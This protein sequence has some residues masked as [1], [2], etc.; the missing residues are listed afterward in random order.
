MILESKQVGGKIC[1]EKKGLAEFVFKMKWKTKSMLYYGC[2]NGYERE[3]QEMFSQI[4]T[5]TER[6]LDVRIMQND[7]DWMMQVLIGP[8]I[9]D[10]D[11]R[12]T[13]TRAVSAFLYKAARIRQILC[14]DKAEV[15]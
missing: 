14:Q 3:R 15:T 13:I 9:F 7:R 11:T 8:G 5:Q 1:Q 12:K 2:N 4:F 6:K 10:H